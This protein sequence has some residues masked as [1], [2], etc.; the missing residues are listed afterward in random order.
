MRNKET[1]SLYVADVTRPTLTHKPNELYSKQSWVVYLC[2]FCNLKYV[3]PTKCF[4]HDLRHL[5]DE[6]ILNFETRLLLNIFISD[7]ISVLIFVLCFMESR[8]TDE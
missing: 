1:H 3:D 6:E 7:S 4:V 5:S 8:Q 2:G